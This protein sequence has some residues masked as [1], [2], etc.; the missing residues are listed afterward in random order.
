ML[1]R[2]EK[3]PI[4]SNTVEISTAR[5]CDDQG[6]FP[7]PQGIAAGHFPLT[8]EDKPILDAEKLPCPPFWTAQNIALQIVFASKGE[9]P[10]K[11]EDG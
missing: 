3:T 1:K 8:Y 5:H 9:N 6:I 11:S 7:R 10:L 4:R 2:K